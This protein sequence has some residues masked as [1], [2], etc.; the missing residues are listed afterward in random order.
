ML[1]IP[2]LPY[3]NGGCQ[4]TD[5][6]IKSIQEIE[7]SLSLSGAQD[8]YAGFRNHMLQTSVVQLN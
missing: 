4:V 7:S 2:V 8:P 6:T 5:G 1:E 3:Q